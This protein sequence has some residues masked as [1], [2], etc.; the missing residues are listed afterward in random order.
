MKFLATEII[1][2]SMRFEPKS[3]PRILQLILA[4]NSLHFF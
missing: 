1:V 4:S 2:I 3:N